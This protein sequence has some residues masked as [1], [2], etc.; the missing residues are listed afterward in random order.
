MLKRWLV[1]FPVPAAA[2]KPNLAVLHQNNGW[3]VVLTVLLSIHNP[4][5]VSIGTHYSWSPSITMGHPRLYQCLFPAA[6]MRAGA[7]SVLC[8]IP[9]TRHSLF[10]FA[11]RTPLSAMFNF[12]CE[13]FSFPS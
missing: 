12:F 1:S 4:L 8:N 11:R 10:P 9:P 2:V 6:V 7:S 13:G 5:L 3:Q